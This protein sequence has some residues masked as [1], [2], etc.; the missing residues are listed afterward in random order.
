V[1]DPDDVMI[2]AERVETLRRYAA[3]GWILAAFAW[4][5]QIA[6]QLTTVQQVEA[7]YDRIR[8]ILQLD[9]DLAYC[10]HPAG[11]PVCWCRKPLPGLLLQFAHRHRVALDR[12]ILVGR[13]LGDR[14]LAFR[15]G[16]TYRDA[17]LLSHSR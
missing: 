12:S 2:P 7:C 9:I 13:A 8:E 11:P 4:R 14:T 5:P 1:L 17:S 15:L 16:M 6:Q 10:P 3:E